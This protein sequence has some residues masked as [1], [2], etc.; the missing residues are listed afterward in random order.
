MPTP[1]PTSPQRRA[2]FPGTSITRD[3]RGYS[4]T[5]HI[6]SHQGWTRQPSGRKKV[7]QVGKGVRDSPCSLC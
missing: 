7:Q 3:I 5:R 4:K 1:T 6:P 2:G